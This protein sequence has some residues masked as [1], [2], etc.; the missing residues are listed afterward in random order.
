MK[1]IIKFLKHKLKRQR[2]RISIWS[3]T[4]FDSNEYGKMPLTDNQKK[5]IAI[6]IKMINNPESELLMTTTSEKRY[7]KY[8]DYF[9]VIGYDSM[10]II[11]HVYSYDV[12]LKGRTFNNVKD[13]FDSRLDA[14]RL[15]METE[16]NENIK[17]SLNIVLE[18][19]KEVNK[20]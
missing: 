6:C 8:Q 15:A 13:L 10:Q 9:L 16:M 1:N 3:K 7:V 2:Q 12:A 20:K 19:L 5:A 18:N 11:N 4:T 17:H 14:D